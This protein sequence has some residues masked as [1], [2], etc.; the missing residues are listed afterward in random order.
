MNFDPPNHYGIKNIINSW[1]P[2]KRDW[3]IAYYG[4][5]YDIV[6]EIYVLGIWNKRIHI[7]NRCHVFYEN[8][9]FEEIVEIAYNEY[10]L[11]EGIY[12]FAVYTGGKIPKSKIKKEFEKIPSESVEVVDTS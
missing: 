6:A 2:S 9:T 1:S 7:D 12:K 8:K 5:S 4:P 11:E 10:T 3:I